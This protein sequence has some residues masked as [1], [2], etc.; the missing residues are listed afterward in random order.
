MQKEQRAQA[1]DGLSP[2]QEEMSGRTHNLATPERH[3]DL[4][5]TN[6]S[7]VG[8][9]PLL[10]FLFTAVLAIAILYFGQSV[11][12]PVAFSLLLTFLLS[13]IVNGLERLRVG[14]ITSVILVVVLTF[15]LLGAIGWIVTLQITTLVSEL[16]QYQQNIRQ[17]V[18]DLRN[19]GKG[20]TI[21]QVQ[22]TVD[23]IKERNGKS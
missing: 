3:P 7:I 21:E 4:Q 11:L 20:G 17:K 16:A 6:G 12:I 8:K 18:V 9:P 10:I 19:M 1:D 15:S 14:K 2:R 13:P 22:K 23:E 5:I